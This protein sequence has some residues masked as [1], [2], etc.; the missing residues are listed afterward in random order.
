M[1]KSEIY[2]LSND[3]KS[4]QL[5]GNKLLANLTQSVR[6]MSEKFDEFEKDHKEKE[7]MINGLTQEVNGLKERVKLLEKVSD[8]HEQYSR[9]NGLLIHGIDEDKDEVNDDIVINMLQY[10]L[11]LEILKKLH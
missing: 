3:T 1:K 4:M 8:Y 9:R 5:K 10:K 7:K 11:E 2:N 6:L